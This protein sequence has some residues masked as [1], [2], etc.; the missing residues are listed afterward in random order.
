[1]E[2]PLSSFSGWIGAVTVSDTVK[3]AQST[4]LFDLGPECVEVGGGEVGGN[5]WGIYSSSLQI[6]CTLLET[7]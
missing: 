4:E 3:H 6:D 1:M 2:K 5:M 7:N